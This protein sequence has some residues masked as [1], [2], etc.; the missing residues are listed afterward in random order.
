MTA[1][2]FES[3]QIPRYTDRNLEKIPEAI[4]VVVESRC[5]AAENDPNG[6]TMRYENVVTNISM[7]RDIHIHESDVR[8]SLLPCGA[9]VWLKRVSMRIKSN[10]NRSSGTLCKTQ[11]PGASCSECWND[12]KNMRNDLARTQ[13]IKR[14]ACRGLRMDQSSPS[15]KKENGTEQKKRKKRRRRDSPSEHSY[16]FCTNVCVATVSLERARCPPKLH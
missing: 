9:A 15:T 2:S 1:G 10:R 7:L 14:N 6:K 11:C 13:R 16:R 5:T 12:G 4:Q 8:N 3:R